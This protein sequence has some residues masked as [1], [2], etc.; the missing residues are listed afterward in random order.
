MKRI[1]TVFN[2]PEVMTARKAVCIAGAEHIVITPLAYQLC[3]D[4]MMDIYSEKRMTESGK[5]VQLD[6]TSEN[7]RS[8]SIVS[9]IRKITHAG[10][11]CLA[12]RHDSPAGRS[13]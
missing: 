6:V 8:G 3:G 11:I 9:A 13:A 12:S 7:S 5:Q 10:I 1:T 2:E 4:E